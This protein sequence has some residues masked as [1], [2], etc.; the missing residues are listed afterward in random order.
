MTVRI[1]DAAAAAAHLGACLEAEG[2]DYA[3]GG[4]IALAAHGL[5]RMTRDADLSVFLARAELAKLFDALARSGCLFDRATATRALDL[6]GFCTVRLG[7]VTCDLFL[8][9]VANSRALARRVRLAVPDAGERW[10]LSVDDL[11]LHKLVMFRGKDRADLEGLFA[12]HG[13]AIDEAYVRE[14]LDLIVPDEPQ[15]RAFLA[16]LVARFAR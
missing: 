4:G 11:V 2:V 10:F 1:D 13:A 8:M 15:R 16:D 12:I 14:R 7:R 6:T 5:V 3:I 9:T